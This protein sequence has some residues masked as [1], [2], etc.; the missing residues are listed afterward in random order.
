MS[1]KKLKSTVKSSAR[2]R[3]RLVT[4]SQAASS[5][6]PGSD[7]DPKHGPGN[8]ESAGEHARV[9]GRGTG[10]VGQT[11]RR[12]RTELRTKSR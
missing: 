12:F 4:G 9:G 3:A 6:G 2:R 11:K 7:H 5:G 10:I 1:L 8:F